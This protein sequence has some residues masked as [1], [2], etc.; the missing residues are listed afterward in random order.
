MWPAARIEP[1][2][3]KAQLTLRWM[4][5]A[6]VLLGLAGAAAADSFDFSGSSM[7]SIFAQGKERTLIRG[8]AWVRSD[9]V[10]IRAGEVEL[11]GKNLQYAECRG[12]VTIVDSDKDITITCASAYYDRSSK[13]TRATGSVVMEDRKNEVIVKSQRLESRSEEDLVI[14]QA[15]VRILKPDLSARSEFA[16]YDRGA[17]K[18]ELSG[19][20]LV[21]RKKD[22][23]RAV[24][25][26]VDLDTDEIRM[27]GEV[28]G[29]IAGED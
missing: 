25:I 13:F 24:R 2:L 23:F 29:S 8:Q 17:K 14:L 15:A 1:V 22:E 18:L 10:E 19:L 7:T 16:R 20:P 21:F 11:Y 4:I 27:I 5:A 3:R 12:G 28:K 9:S 26:I 6:V